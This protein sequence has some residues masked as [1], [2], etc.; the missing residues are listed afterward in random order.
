MFSYYSKFI[1]NFSQKIYPLNRNNVFPVSDSVLQAFRS[2]K[3]DLKDAA[4]RSIDWQTEFVVET[5]ASDFCIAATLNQKGRPV[6]FFS[7][8][9]SPSEIRHHSVEKEAAAIVESIASGV[10]I[11]LGESLSF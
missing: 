11:L 8:T 6:A 3:L 10:T 2:L 9:L 7:R 1:E 5:D 4:L